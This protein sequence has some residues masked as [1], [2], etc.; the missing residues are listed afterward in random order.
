MPTWLWWLV[1]AVILAGAETLSLDFVLIMCAG[2]AGAGAVAA[3]A[4]AAAPVQFGVAIVVALGLLLFI[5]PI[6]RRHLTVGSGHLTG[7]AALVGKP[8]VVLREVDSHDGRVRLNG[9]EWSARSMLDG[10]VFPAGTTVRV[11]EI[12]GATAVVFEEPFGDRLTGSG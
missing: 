6:A 3:A 12:V 1:A 7:T 5:R 10:Q 9:G 2:G 11:H 8:A 4:G